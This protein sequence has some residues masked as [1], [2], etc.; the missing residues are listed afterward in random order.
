[1]IEKI[2]QSIFLSSFFFILAVLLHGALP[3]NILEN[4]IDEF[5]QTERTKS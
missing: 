1:M 5:I 2:C 3:L 4:V